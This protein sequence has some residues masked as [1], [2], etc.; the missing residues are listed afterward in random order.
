MKC[1]VDGTPPCRRCRHANAP[2]VFKPRSNVGA[3]PESDGW[4]CIML[5]VYRLRLPMRLC[6][7]RRVDN[8]QLSYLTWNNLIQLQGPFSTGWTELR[9]FSGSTKEDML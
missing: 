2:C 8:A 4:S 7:Y 1:E 3:N 5:T 6:H 9:Q